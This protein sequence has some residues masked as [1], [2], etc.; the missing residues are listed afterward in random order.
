MPNYNKLLWLVLPLFGGCVRSEERT[1]LQQAAALHLEAVQIAEALED[2][3]K[4]ATILSD[5]VAV[6]RAEIEVWEKDLVEVPGFEHTSN[7]SGHQHLHEPV[8]VTAEEMFQLQSESKKRIEQIK[9][10]VDA[11]TQ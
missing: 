5:S 8:Q 2:Q 7:H 10:R 11:I 1:H 4:Q 6:L 3:L 9:K